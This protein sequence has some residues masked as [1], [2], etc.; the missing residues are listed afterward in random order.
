MAIAG[1]VLSLGPATPAYGALRA[2]FPPMK[3]LRDPSRFV[4]L[5]LVAVA[6]LAPLGLT[7]L[8]ARLSG[9]RGM[10]AAIGVVAAVNLETL[11]APLDYVRFEGFSPI[12]RR[13]AETPGAVLAEFP[14]YPAAEVYR[15][16]SYVLAS[17]QHWKPLV[18]GYSGFTP[19][20]FVGRGDLLRRFPDDAAVQE[21]RRL[22]VTLVTVHFGR[23]GS[24]RAREVA[25]RLAACADLE[26]LAAGPGGERLYRLRP[27]S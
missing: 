6:L 13:V 19:P 11:C 26:P 9:A 27:G 24:A 18:N 7:A 8:R 15:N 16:A 25:E 21:L 1:F 2:L 10:L 5:V 12:Y 23:Y 14:F 20:S 22:G 4:Y 3:T 17:T